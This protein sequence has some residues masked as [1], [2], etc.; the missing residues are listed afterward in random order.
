MYNEQSLCLKY[1]SQ[2]VQTSFYESTPPT[3]DPLG[4][5]ISP[6]ARRNSWHARTN[7]PLR[8]RSHEPWRWLLCLRTGRG[9]RCTCFPAQQGYS[10][11]A[12]DTGGRSNSDSPLVVNSHGF[13]TYFVSVWIIHCFFLTAKIFCHNRIRD[14]SRT[15]SRT[16][17][18][19][20]DDTTRQQAFRRGL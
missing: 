4:N 8:F 12:V 15:E 19:H 6:G 16:I 17:C 11:T 2:G 3:R 20:G 1:P 9:G 7:I 13:H 18:T 5:K 14:T 10:E